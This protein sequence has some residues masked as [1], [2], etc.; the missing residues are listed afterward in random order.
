MQGWKRQDQDTWT[1]K[2]PPP[3]TRAVLRCGV[4]AVGRTHT[5]GADAQAA[6]NAAIDL[7]AARL[8]RAIDDAA[9]KAKRAR[10]ADSRM[11]VHLQMPGGLPGQPACGCSGDDLLVKRA[12]VGLSVRQRWC[13]RCVRV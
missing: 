4:V 1:R 7:E 11:V 10:E 5:A 3:F 12:G 13:S 2:L 9:S 8:K 6:L